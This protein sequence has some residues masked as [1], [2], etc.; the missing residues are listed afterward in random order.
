MRISGFNHKDRFNA[1]KGAISRY[2]QIESEIRTGNRKLIYRLGNQIRNAKQAKKDWP[3]TWFL[4]EDVR[5]T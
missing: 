1:I 4:K 3:N 5:N 2:R